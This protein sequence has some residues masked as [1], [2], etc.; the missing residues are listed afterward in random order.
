MGGKSSDDCAHTERSAELESG[1]AARPSAKRYH[2]PE[3]ALERGPMECR[4]ERGHIVDSVFHGDG[5]ATP[6]S[7]AIFCDVCRLRRWLEVEGALALAQAEVGLI[8]DTAAREI[9]VAAEALGRAPD[10]DALAA[11]I[12]RTGHSLVPLLRALQARCGGAAG[13]L[14]H[15]GATTQD[16][17]D[18]AQ[19]L[20]LRQVYD[21]VER[22]VS[23]LLEA[24]APLARAHARQ[25][26]LGRTHGVPAL[27]MTF[28]LKVAGWLDALM[29]D[30]E[31]LREARERVLVAQLFGGVGTQAGFQG[32]GPAPLACF[33]RRLGLSAPHIGWH[34]SRDRLAEL[35]SN[36]AILCA[37]L[38][39]IAD[40]VRT[41]SRPEIGELRL[42]WAPEQVG[43]STM[44]HKRNPEGCEQV[45]AL[46]RL[47]RAKLPLMLDAMVLE[48]ERDYRGTR[49]EWAVLADASHHA[50]AALAL[51]SAVVQGLEVDAQR[52][53]ANARAHREG[54][55]TEALMLALAPSL[56]K[57]SA[58]ERVRALSGQAGQQGGGLEGLVLED[59]QLSGLLTPSELARVFDPAQ[60]LGES[61]RLV[62]GVLDALAA[63]GGGRRGG[64][65]RQASRR[66]TSRDSG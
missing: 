20:E 5:Y 13:E 24:L 8:P 37:T 18:T 22:D 40:E 52:M 49:L 41:L 48:H 9:A 3:R 33:A 62:A 38:A 63:R 19:S 45:V 28:G 4:H 66:S 16:I 55:C 27:P 39:R 42:G 26:M 25:L 60:H 47:V 56:G 61:E 14:V 50:L 34:V 2:P 51:V 6:E 44:P 21:A 57:Q 46:S 29:R 58:F 36:L 30:Q 65:L 31:R 53:E 35:V 15:L 43:S 32:R 64:D 12:H 11:E 54:I 59:A 10:L 7:R 23:G 1:E 17:Q